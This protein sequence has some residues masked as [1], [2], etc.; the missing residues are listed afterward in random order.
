M[1]G[2]RLCICN[3]S[4]QRKENMPLKLPTENSD[5]AKSHQSVTA[6]GVLQ[7]FMNVLSRRSIPFHRL[8]A[9]LPAKIS[10]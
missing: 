2:I 3:V 7:G 6:Q 9:P 5:P 1:T 10:P 4:I 8:M